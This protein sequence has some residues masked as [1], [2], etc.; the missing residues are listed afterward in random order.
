MTAHKILVVDDDRSLRQFLSIWLKLEGYAVRACASGRD[1]LHEMTRDPAAVVLTDLTMEGIDGMGVLTSVKEHWP[2]TEVVMITAYGTTENAVKAMKHGAYDYITKPF[3]IE[4]LKLVLDKVFERRAMV[5]E[6]TALRKLLEDR[7]GYGSMVGRSEPML[8]VYD[9]MD[10]IKDTPVGVLIRGESGTGKELVARAL[11]YESERRDKPFRSINCGAIP[12]NLIESELFGYQK[13]AFTGANKDHP[14]LFRS[15]DGGTLF[16]DEIGEM[17]LST[18]VKVLRALQERRIR[19]VGGSEETPVDVRVIAATNRDLPAEVAANRFREDLYY[20]L[21]V[22]TI[23]LPALRER[24]GDLP[25]LAQHFV[26]KY[27]EQFG[28][29][30]IEVSPEAMRALVAHTWP[31]NVRELENAVQRGVALSRGELVTP[32][33]LPPEIAGGATAEPGLPLDVPSE[34][35]DLDGALERYERML[36]ES[37]LE[38]A[39]GVKT[40]A[41]KLLRITFRSFRY[42]LQKLGLEEPSTRG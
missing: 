30:G 2:E 28:R 12:E 35:M 16:L 40:E 24:L 27:A 21:N 8:A 36:I 5:V 37:A 14:G 32:E 4:E 33:S 10:R 34:G 17:P 7:F 1:A 31:G 18:Q 15:A 20:R 23:A 38:A 26:E 19:P 6:N 41:A 25:L 39:G 11:H 29:P 3:N 42:R 9:L 22:V 13:G